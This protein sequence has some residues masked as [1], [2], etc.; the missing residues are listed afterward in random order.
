MKEYDAAVRNYPLERC[1]RAVSLIT[2]YDYKS[3]G[4]AGAGE[5]TQA[6]LL[7]ELVVKL[8]NI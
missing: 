7:Q 3:K 5:A 8:L 4:G 6:E 2:E 1:I